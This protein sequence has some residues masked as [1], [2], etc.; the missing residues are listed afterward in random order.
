M[1][2][3]HWQAEISPPHTPHPKCCMRGPPP[4]TA[5]LTY[6]QGSSTSLTC[7]WGCGTGRP[8]RRSPWEGWHAPPR[9][10]RRGT[11]AWA[12]PGPA[13]MTVVGRSS[14]MIVSNEEGGGGK[15]VWTGCLEGESDGVVQDMMQ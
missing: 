9:G 6:P 1:G 14:A 7:G 3:W 2:L 15:S 12:A 11:R 8:A 5:C 10:W 13:R 4:S